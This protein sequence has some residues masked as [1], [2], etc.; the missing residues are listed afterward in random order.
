LLGEEEEEEEEVQ[1]EEEA[2]KDHH[3]ARGMVCLISRYT[4]ENNNFLCK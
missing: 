3:Q 4:Y 2:E 1:V